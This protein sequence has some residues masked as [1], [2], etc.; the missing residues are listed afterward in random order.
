MRPAK[1]NSRRG[2][3]TEDGASPRFVDHASS[4]D[5]EI[6]SVIDVGGTID[7]VVYAEFRLRDWS[8][9]VPSIRSGK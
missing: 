7:S 4:V 6:D 3:G 2:T 1:A 8:E 5:D 9:L